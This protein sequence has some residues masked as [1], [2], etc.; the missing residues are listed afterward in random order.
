MKFKERIVHF[1]KTIEVGYYF[2]FIE[3]ILFSAGVYLGT[4]ENMSLIV[5]ALI[6]MFFVYIIKCLLEIK[7]KLVME[8]D[9]WKDK[10]GSLLIKKN[11]SSILF[12]PFITRSNGTC[13]VKLNISSMDITVFEPSLRVDYIGKISDSCIIDSN[14]MLPVEEGSSHRTHRENVEFTFFEKEN[15][16]VAKIKPNAS[17]DG[18]Y[19]QFDFSFPEQYFERFSFS[20]IDSTDRHI[21]D[22]DFNY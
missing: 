20:L 17:Q 1:L 22:I 18:Q 12:A 3:F 16:N 6:L 19:F 14:V 8:V 11:Q 13:Y 21:S 7:D 10:L 4:T 2:N 9:H 15:M 5:V